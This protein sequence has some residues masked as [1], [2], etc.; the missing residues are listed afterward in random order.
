MRNKWYL[1]AILSIVFCYCIPEQ[2]KTL[3]KQVKSLDKS[4]FHSLIQALSWVLVVLTDRDGREFQCRNFPYRGGRLFTSGYLVMLDVN[5]PM[6]GCGPALLRETLFLL[7][8]WWQ[9]RW[10]HAFSWKLGQPGDASLPEWKYSIGWSRTFWCFEGRKFH[11]L[12]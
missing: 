9:L 3:T 5:A 8:K 7:Q 12:W 2:I 11:V 1:Y 4:I 6:P 10:I